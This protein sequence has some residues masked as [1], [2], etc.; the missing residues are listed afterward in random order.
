MTCDVR[1]E[2]P[3]TFYWQPWCMLSRSL[4]WSVCTRA[5][6]T[7]PLPPLT[8]PERARDNPNAHLP[9]LRTHKTTPHRRNVPS[10][11]VRTLAATLLADWWRMD[12][13]LLEENIP[14][15]IACNIFE[16]VFRCPRIYVRM[17]IQAHP[18]LLRSENKLKTILS[19]N[20]IP[21]A[22]MEEII[23]LS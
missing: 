19:N 20:A 22:T 5:S 11:V 10:T 8:P 6:D 23:L 12:M 3:H 13:D 2:E 14:T 18:F 7:T 15:R 16:H 1:V 4:R 9:H 17:R 21:R